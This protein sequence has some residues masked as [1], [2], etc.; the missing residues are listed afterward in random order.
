MPTWSAAGSVD[1]AWRAVAAI[2]VG[3][4]AGSISPAYWLGRLVKGIDVRVHGSRN[5]GA[6]NVYHLLGPWAAA[7]TAAI[8]L[9]KG[10]AAV[11]IARRLLGLP[12]PWGELAGV[13]AVLGH[14]FPFYLRFR[15]G[16][17]LATAV[18]LYLYL[19]ALAMESGEFFYGTLLAVLATAALL[20]AASRSGDLTGLV[21]FG[22]LGIVTPLE[23][24][25]TAAGL[26]PWALAL[27]LFVSSIG[28]C[29]RHQ[30]FQF[31]T[32]KELK[33]WRIIAR[34]FA[35]L[36]IPIDL[37]FHRTP[38]LFLLG[39]LALIFAGLDLVRLF[40][41]HQ[42]VQLFKKSEVKRFSSMTS[43]LVAIFIIFLAFPARVPY[44]GLA[45][46]TLGDLFSKIVGIRFGRHEL[47]KGR[48]LEGTLA[49]T[50]GSFLAAWV[51]FVVFRGGA[52]PIPLYA[53]LSGPVFAAL[54][55]LFSG[56][57]DDNFT[58]GVISSGFL[59]A[60]RYFL[61]V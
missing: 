30:V 60:L 56:R 42:L 12:A 11:L 20:F 51:L 50:A 1:A 45:F 3:Y 22:F 16:R 4:L 32:Q 54:V 7:V 59:S 21:A 61:R 23:L 48:T 5:A 10:V 37:L 13:A 38:L 39:V 58:V 29:L 15:G 2:L 24:G 9:G 46:I 47:Q 17:G 25:L 40:T 49:F 33:W 31:R 8:D 55:E 44:L 28:N 18:G 41:R 57:L 43:F 27:F 53:V 35:L 19:C 14:I 6:R 34:P 26:L 52:V 36:F